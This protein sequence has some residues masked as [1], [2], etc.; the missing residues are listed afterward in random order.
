MDTAPGTADPARLV[1]PA[2]LGR[3]DVPRLC[4]QLT[5]LYAAG[6][7]AAVCDVGQ[8]DADLTVVDALARLRLT[9]LRAGRPLAV[10]RA[11][12]GLRA[13]LGLLGLAVELLGEA[14]EREPAPGVQE[15]VQSRDPAI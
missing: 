9:A 6:A 4:A 8:V 2:G 14:E 10:E 15:E 5:A 11:G 13:L 7:A 3:D 1:V 12:P